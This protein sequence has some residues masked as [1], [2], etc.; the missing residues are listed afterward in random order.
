MSFKVFES[1]GNWGVGKDGGGL[2]IEGL[3][4]SYDMYNRLKDN[5]AR[6][7][8]YFERDSE[9]KLVA[10]AAQKTDD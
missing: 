3:E 2:V 10:K 4:I 5:P 6:A 8:D 7:S 1:N 9:G